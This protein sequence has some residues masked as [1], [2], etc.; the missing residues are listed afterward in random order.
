MHSGVVRFASC[1]RRVLRSPTSD[2]YRSGWSCQ[3]Y[4]NLYTIK[5]VLWE[6]PSIVTELVDADNDANAPLSSIRRF[7]LHIV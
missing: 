3:A 4:L 1:I 6:C 7:L 5:E 2:K